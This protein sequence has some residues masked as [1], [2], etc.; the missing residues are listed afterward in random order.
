MLDI[1]D[2]QYKPTLEEIS[3]YIKNP[4]FDSFCA[5]MLNTYEPISK[6][7]YSGDSNL[8]GWNIKLRKAGRALCAVYPK[9]GYFS[10][11]VVIGKREKER[12]ELLLPALSQ[13][14][15]ALYRNTVEGMGQRWLM[16]DIKS[17]NAL[18]RDTL[19]LIRLRREKP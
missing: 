2:M 14:M 15:Q 10:L 4:L 5:Y 18:Y 13:D 3:G 7:E 19:K 12:A 11:L 8:Q 6:M 16:I 9:P 1:K 17:D